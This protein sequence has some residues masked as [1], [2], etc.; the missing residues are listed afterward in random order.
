MINDEYTPDLEQE[1]NETQ[2]EVEETLGELENKQL[3]E[4]ATSTKPE[5]D[6]KAEA[7][8]W[9]EEAWK[10]KQADKPHQSASKKSDELD[11]GAKAFLKSSG[12]ENSEFDFVKEEL[13]K[14][15]LK[16]LDSLL[17]NPYF[18]SELENRRA[19][20]KTKNATI[21]GKSANGV[22]TDS[23]DYWL[24]KPIDEVPREMRYKVV[25]AKMKKDS[26]SGMFYNS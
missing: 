25:Q 13:K 11:Y 20:D 12:I 10:L 5:K 17:E 16:D 1:E 3:K 19:L 14:S 4:E 23:V 21:K 8:K 26:S 22:A 6:W 15:G 24:T 9:R 18:K 7:K 2:E